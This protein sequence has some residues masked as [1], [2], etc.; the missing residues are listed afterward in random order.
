MCRIIQR[1]SQEGKEKIKEHDETRI[2]KIVIKNSKEGSS[3]VLNRK[4]YD[5]ND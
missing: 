4:C 2:K 1:I 3:Y 5:V